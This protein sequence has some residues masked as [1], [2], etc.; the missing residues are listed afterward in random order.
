MHETMTQQG[1]QIRQPYK[2][3]GYR[4]IAVL[5]GGEVIL[6]DASGKR[7]LW[8]RKD[9]YSGYVVTIN[10]HAYEFVRSL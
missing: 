3:A 4:L 8:S 5:P 1:S 6:A 10:R 9:D 2:A 7:E